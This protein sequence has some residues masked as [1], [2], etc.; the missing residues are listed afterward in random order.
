MQPHAR[1]CQVQNAAAAE[2]RLV[3][4]AAD[5]MSALGVS[6][7]WLH[8]SMPGTARCAVRPPT[9]VAKQRLVARQAA[10][11]KSARPQPQAAS[12]PRTASKLAS[13]EARMAR[14]WRAT[15]SAP[16]GRQAESQA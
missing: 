1:H 10:Q 8:M 15:P 14:A 3:R 6:R 16:A 11:S 7:S 9:T 13:S 5:L 2:H 12:R 4:V